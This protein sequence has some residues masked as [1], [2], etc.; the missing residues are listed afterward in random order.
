[1]DESQIVEVWTL[2][3]E[4]ID[5]KNQE[6]AAERFVDLLADYGVADDVLTSTL[7]SDVVLDGAINYF[8]D[9]DEEN[10]ADDDSWE[11]ED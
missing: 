10:F 9:I 4:Y 2:F 8:L 3:K 7:G 11:D 5:K 1:M 6:L